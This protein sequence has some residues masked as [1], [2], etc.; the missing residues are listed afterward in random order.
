MNKYYKNTFKL[1]LS[2]K[3]NTFFLILFNIFMFFSILFLTYDFNYSQYNHIKYTTEINNK[4]NH[5]YIFP[6]YKFDMYRIFQNIENEISNKNFKEDDFRYNY[7]KFIDKEEKKSLPRQNDQE[8]DYTFLFTNNNSYII[9]D[10]YNILSM[11]EIN[12][13]KN[14]FYYD[15]ENVIKPQYKQHSTFSHYDEFGE[16]VYE[17]YPYEKQEINF[18]NEYD[19]LYYSVLTKKNKIEVQFYTDEKRDFN[20]LQK[21]IILEPNKIYFE[22][23]K[24]FA[25]NKIKYNKNVDS[26]NDKINK[27]LYYY[28]LQ[29]SLYIFLFLF[30]I[31]CIPFILK[32]TVFYLYKYNSN[33]SKQKFNNKK[34]YF[35]DSLI[36]I[37]FT[38]FCYSTITFLNQL[39]SIS[40]FNDK[41]FSSH[42]NY[43][44]ETSS[45]DDVLYLIN[46]IDNIKNNTKNTI[47][48][49]D[50]SKIY[51]LINDN[52]RIYPNLL[53][54][55][56]LYIYPTKHS[57]SLFHKGDTKI[58]KNSND[59]VLFSKFNIEQIDNYQKL[60][61][62]NHGSFFLNNKFYDIVTSREDFTRIE[63]TH[64]YS[65]YYAKNNLIQNKVIDQIFFNKKEFYLVSDGIIT[66]YNTD[67]S[68]IHNNPFVQK[69]D[70]ISNK[71]SY[72]FLIN[73]IFV[74]FIFL[75]LTLSYRRKHFQ[76]NRKKIKIIHVDN[77]INLKNMIT[78]E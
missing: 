1:L 18:F 77:K 49:K 11:A 16:A 61:N 31:N 44:Q 8:I 58:V 22:N 68:F 74:S 56:S 32:K 72:D 39:Y 67:V 4:N 73:N 27:E 78:K 23:N 3:K 63:I 24:S 40:L 14:K 65:V 43:F 30:I 64:D 9:K 45:K 28:L 7:H 25:Y 47:Q 33:Q 21:V 70:S 46:Q 38:Y 15:F 53:N 57:F 66:Y 2:I 55:N 48:D 41:K 20:S 13:L 34:S 12:N 50:Y 42:F 37:F 71:I 35:I 59:E 51:Q 75:T 69:F 10:E 76:S 26:L 62:L 29:K 36:F 19:G 52:N 5:T 17:S 6:S 54:D 60:K